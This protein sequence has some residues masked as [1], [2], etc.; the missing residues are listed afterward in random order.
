MAVWYGG[1][2]A[3]AP[4][5][6][7][8]D[9][10][11][12]E[13]W[14]KHL[15]AIRA[16]GFN[17]VKTWVDW[18]MAE[19]REESFRLRHEEATKR[20]VTSLAQAA[21]VTSEAEVPGR[22]A[23]DSEVRRLVSERR[24]IVFVFNHAKDRVDLKILCACYSHGEQRA[25]SWTTGRLNFKRSVKSPCFMGSCQGMALGFWNWKAS[26]ARCLRHQCWEAQ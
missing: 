18:S 21:G 5:Q 11:S 10:T 12:A 19:P 4:M 22:G 26:E 24:Q 9:A 17:T 25:S 3:R 8:L 2:K 23:S 16:A 15:D 1:G 13:R 6:E 14:G 7:R 20:F